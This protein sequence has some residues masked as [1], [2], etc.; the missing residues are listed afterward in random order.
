VFDNILT[1]GRIFTGQQH[2]TITHDAKVVILT[3]FLKVLITP[4]T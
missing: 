1:C 3:D 2:C 4:V